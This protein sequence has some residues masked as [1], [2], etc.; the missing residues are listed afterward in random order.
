MTPDPKRPA[1]RRVKPGTREHR[2][3]YA[4]VHARGVRCRLCG[5]PD[6]TAH[7]LVPRSRGGDDVRDNL[8]PICT[9]EHDEYE[10]GR[11]RLMVGQ[12]IRL[13]LE[14][15]ELAYIIDRAGVGF[16]DRYYP[17]VT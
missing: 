12:A 7:H 4:K 3:V 9:R 11:T 15:A 5:S 2:E 14:P 6:V 17:A 13:A 8:F 16:L 1:R 10:R